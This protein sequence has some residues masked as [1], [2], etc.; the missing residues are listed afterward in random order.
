MTKR[1]YFLGAVI[2]LLISTTCAAQ[3]AVLPGSA[4][5]K[6]K[7]EEPTGTSGKLILR[8]IS[9]IGT[10][11]VHPFEVGVS[12][13]EI[14]DGNRPDQVRYDLLVVFQNNTI[15]IGYD[16]LNALIKGISYLLDFDPNILAL[17]DPQAIEVEYR[18]NNGLLIKRRLKPY[19]GMDMFGTTNSGVPLKIEELRAFQIL[20]IKAKEKLDAARS[21]KSI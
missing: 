10:T 17:Q 12:T 4:P 5:V 9:A 16:E 15:S 18:T 2:S 13:R 8:S 19:P 20:I 6:P 7:L 14:R 3:T 11:G 1:V 21:L